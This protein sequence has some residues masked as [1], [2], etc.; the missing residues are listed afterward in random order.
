MRGLPTGQVKQDLWSNVGSIVQ[1]EQH[2]NELIATSR[3]QVDLQHQLAKSMFRFRFVTVS[4]GEIQRIQDFSPS[5]RKRVE[6]GTS[7][8]T[9]EHGKDIRAPIFVLTDSAN[10]LSE[11]DDWVGPDNRIDTFMSSD[12]ACHMLILVISRI[13]DSLDAADVLYFQ[14]PS[15]AYPPSS[16]IPQSSCLR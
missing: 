1:E 3:G 10:H 14:S 12:L 5:R 13:S 7:Y 11:I 6:T 2:E 8:L 4:G 16:W 9:I 15:L